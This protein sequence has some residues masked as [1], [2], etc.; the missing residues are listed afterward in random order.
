MEYNIRCFASIMALSFFQFSPYYVLSS[1]QSLL[2]IIL[3]CFSKYYTVRAELVSWCFEPSRPQGITSKWKKGMDVVLTI[4][5]K[6]LSKV[7][8]CYSKQACAC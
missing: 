5:E 1:F 4:S 8:M 7:G 2:C 3:I 6:V